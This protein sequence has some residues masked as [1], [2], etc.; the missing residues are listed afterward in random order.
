[1]LS[2]PSR[3]S[4]RVRVKSLDLPTPTDQEDSDQRESAALDKLS[5]SERRITQPSMLSE[6][7]S[8]LVRR[9]DSSH[10]RFRDSSPTPD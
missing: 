2:L 7:K 6:E 3:Y 9:L 10:Q 8:K 4:S 5:P 1:M